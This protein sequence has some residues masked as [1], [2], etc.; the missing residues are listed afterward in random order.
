[1]ADEELRVGRRTRRRRSLRSRRAA[2]RTCSAARFTARPASV[3]ER[4]AP[5][6]AV[7]GREARV[8]AAHGDALGRQP[9]SSAAICAK[10]VRAP[11]P[12][13]VV[14][15]RTT[16]LPSASMRTIA[17]ETGCAPAASR[18][19]D[20]AATRRRGLRSSSQP[21][22]SATFST[23]PTRSASSGL[24]PARSSSPGV[25]RFCAPHLERV[26]PGASGEL[27]DLQLAD[28][29]QVRRAEGAVRA[30]GR[31]VRV[32]AGGVDAVRLPA[33]RA[34]RGVAGGRGDARPV[35]R[36]GAG[37]EPALDLAA[38]QPA[39]ARHRR[40]HAAASCR[41]GASSPSTPPTRFW[42]RTGRP[43]LRASAT[44]IGSIFVYDFEPKPPPRYGTTMRTF[45]IGTSKS[46]AISARTRNGMLA[47]RPERDLV[48]LDL[49]DDR[50][51]LH[52]VLVDG[53]E[54]VLALDDDVGVREDRLDLAAVDAVA[55][56]DVALGAA[57]ARR[58][59][60]RAPG[61]AGRS[62]TRGASGRRAPARSCR[63]PA[64]SS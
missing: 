7:V 63:R 20:S 32:D 48:A 36:V 51:R 10:T 5:G 14:P 18:P 24:P 11:W 34:G 39:L 53:R 25:Q 12:T 13:S 49:R 60:G 58:G 38:E 45:A 54:R 57:S 37:V 35:V 40:A 21:I 55:V 6:R 56:A 23:S 44:V 8:G 4:L 50:V 29:L 27:V 64:S 30:G 26:E 15:T 2:R 28:P 42:I 22:A 43:A 17:L 9:S 52:R 19:T 16:A 1:M 41:G 3:V 59:R 31:G 61:A 62:C 46:A 47:R 33:I